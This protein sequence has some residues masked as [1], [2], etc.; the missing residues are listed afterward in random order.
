MATEA[1][2]KY[3][4]LGKSELK[5]V[6]WVEVTDLNKYLMRFYR[7]KAEIVP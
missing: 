1:Q 7:T 4:T 2:V 5:A 3:T 6:D